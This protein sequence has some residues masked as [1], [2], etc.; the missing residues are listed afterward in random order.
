MIR[1]KRLICFSLILALLAGPVALALPNAEAL[2]DARAAGVEMN[3]EATLDVTHL[4]TMMAAA[5]DGSSAA[6]A[7]GAEAQAAWNQKIQDSG[8][9]FAETAFFETDKAPA[10]IAVAIAEYLVDIGVTELDGAPVQFRIVASSKNLRSGPDREYERVGSFPSGTIVTSLG[11]SENGWLQVTDGELTGWATAIHMAPYDGTPAPNWF[12]PSNITRPG[13]GG[14]DGNYVAP[15]IDHTQDELFWLAL[16]IMLEAG[17]DW[18]CDEHQRMVG[19]VVLNRVEHY[20]FPPTTIHG[21][22]HQPGQ[23]PWAANRVRIPI[24]ERAWANAQWLLDGGRVLPPNV[25]FQAQ[26]RQ[27]DGTFATFHCDILGT[28]HFFGYLGSV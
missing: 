22:V 9:D 10:E 17:S 25:V 2:E 6:L 28:T 12:D 8:L 23:Y 1:M 26:F 27:G 19:N 15:P 24:S 16:T 3:M 21:I 18:I 5:R 7:M 20:R 4:E 14:N 13:V 11:R